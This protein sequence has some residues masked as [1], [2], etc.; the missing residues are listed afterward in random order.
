MKFNIFEHSFLWSLFNSLKNQKIYSKTFSLKTL[1]W[2]RLRI[3]FCIFLIWT[4]CPTSSFQILYF[5][6][7]FL[8]GKSGPLN[9]IIHSFVALLAYI[10]HQVFFFLILLSS[11]INLHI[12]IKK[13]SQN[14][15]HHFFKTNLCLQSDISLPLLNLLHIFKSNCIP[16]IRTSYL[17]FIKFWNEESC[18]IEKLTQNFHWG[19][20]PI[21]I[22]IFQSTMGVCEVQVR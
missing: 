18:R 7:F 13:F 20:F 17:N 19:E 9:L 10:Y 2:F 12:K 11:Q 4:P 22:E 15:I 8:L 14:S 16:H 5:W 3:Y 1:S 6:E 21:I